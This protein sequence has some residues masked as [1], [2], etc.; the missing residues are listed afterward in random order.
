MRL[1]CFFN[2]GPLYREDIFLKIDNTFSTQFYFGKINER[3]PDNIK[4]MVY[5]KLKNKP[6][7]F[8]NK[9]LFNKILWRTKAPFLGFKNFD[10]FLI[11]ADFN[12]SYIPLV[13]ICKIL[14]KR[15]YGWGHGIK[16]RN[17]KLHKVEN[18]LFSNFTGFFSYGEKGRKRM[19]ELGYNPNKIHVIYNSLRGKLEHYPNL[20]SS[21]YTDHFGN[22]NP[23]LLFIGRLTPQKKLDKLIELH[24]NLNN[25]GTPCNLVIIGDG[26][27]RNNLEKC[28][29][30]KGYKDKIWF[31]GECYDENKNNELIYNADLCVSPGN[32]GLTAIHALQYGTPIISHD[33]FESQGPEYESII[34]YKTGLTFTKGDWKDLGNKVEEWLRFANGKRQEIREYCYEEINHKWNSDNQIEILKKVLLS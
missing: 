17:R 7:F 5:S 4:E 22:S 32:V 29:Y 33:D 13:L 12:L 8:I 21:I 28:A 18:W 26:I 19:I 6:K 10:T 20:S 15:I 23:V 16:N 14:R 34:P 11:T 30:Q 31:Y 1:C 2:Y 9:Q 25:S 27:E 24:A 3:T